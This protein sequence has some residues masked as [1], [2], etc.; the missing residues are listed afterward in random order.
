MLPAMFAAALALCFGLLSTLSV[1]ALAQPPVSHSPDGYLHGWSV[2]TFATSRNPDTPHLYYL[3]DGNKHLLALDSRSGRVIQNITHWDVRHS[4]RSIATDSRGYVHV[5]STSNEE[6]YHLAVF[7]AQ[8]RSLKNVSMAGLRP[9]VAARDILQMDIDSG[10]SVYIFTS[11]PRQNRPNNER[12]WVLNPRQWTQQ[13]TWIA[14]IPH[15]RNVT[16]AFFYVFAI[17]S[18]DQLYFQ[19]SNRYQTLYITDTSG[20]L[21][22]SKDLVA[23]TTAPW[24][25]NL[26]IDAQFNMWHTYQGSTYVAALDSNG[27]YLAAYDVMS[28]NTFL[29]RSID[30][31]QRGWII[32]SDPVENA[33]LVLSPT[34]GDIVSTLSPDTPSLWTADD[35]FADYTGRGEASL[36]FSSYGT[37]YAVQRMSVDDKDAGRLLQRLSLPERLSEYCNSMDMDVGTQTSNLYVLLDCFYEHGNVFSQ[38]ALVYVMAPSGRAVSEF[39]VDGYAYRLRVDESAALMYAA[40]G[41]SQETGDLV[42]AYSYTNGLQVKNYTAGFQNI[43]DVIVLPPNPHDG[44]TSL[45]V[46]DTWNHRFVTL[47]PGGESAPRVQAYSNDSYCYD[48]AYSLNRQAMLFYVSCETVSWVDGVYSASQ[49]I[50]RWDITEAGSPRV[51]DTYIAPV[52]VE[53]NFLRIVVGYEHNAA[54]AHNIPLI[55]LLRF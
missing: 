7:D 13:A 38:Q 53:A 47:Y 21:Q 24:I 49:N 39:R 5:V 11:T 48:A 4:M 23:N 27:N 20:E 52:G 1:P 8:L 36:Y 31:D 30:V 51:T 34:T 26:V 45:V 41:G 44:T 32:A 15:N 9:A 19:Q 25:D 37:P 12:V 46:V 29:S 43:Y 10:N 33:L 22:Y 16:T 55:A 6:G 42:V 50:Q 17:D 28:A 54:S 35:I 14:P 40:V 18:Q 3:V 2:D